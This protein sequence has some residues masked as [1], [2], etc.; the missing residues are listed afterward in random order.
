MISFTGLSPSMAALSRAF[1]YQSKSH[2]EVLQPRR[3]KS[4]RFG[5]VRFRS[6]LLTES[7][8]FLFL[9]LLRCFTSAGSLCMP[10]YS[11]YSN[12][13]LHQLGSPIRKSPDQSV[14]T[15]P[16]SLSQF[17]HVLLRLLLPRHPP[18]A[19]QCLF[20]INTSPTT[21]LVSR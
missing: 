8:R 17:C 15:T 1:Y 2:V 18:G 21:Q 6:P 13:L 9:C 7:L 10:M 16:R 19:L 4:L 12:W 20:T 14:L 3:D 11:A 5:L